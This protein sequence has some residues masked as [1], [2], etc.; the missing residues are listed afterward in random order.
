MQFE[1]GEIDRAILALR[2]A[3]E[4]EHRLPPTARG[5][6]PPDFLKLI[7]KLTGLA[8]FYGGVVQRS[9]QAGIVGQCI[10]GHVTRIG[11]L[12]NGDLTHA[13]IELV[14]LEE[15]TSP[16]EFLRTEIP[17]PDLEEIRFYKAV[18]LA[19]SPATDHA[20]G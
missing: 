7:A 9:K 8:P 6:V 15:G 11:L 13:A 1:I 19:P 16:P 5:E 14:R 20:D 17:F 4:R 12:T 3:L 10:T 18:P 2:T